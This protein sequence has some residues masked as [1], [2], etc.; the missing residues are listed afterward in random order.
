MSYEKQ[1]WTTGEVI[2]AEKLNHMEDGIGSC[3]MVATATEDGE[4]I[5]LDKTYN[6]INNHL[7]SGGMVF[8]HQQQGDDSYSTVFVSGVS[9]CYHRIPG[10]LYGVV[11]KG[12]RDELEFQ[13]DSPDGV[14]RIEPAQ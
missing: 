8:V 13:S 7:A 14:L 10:N 4:F 12:I 1:T 6:E 9:V 5:V 2:T 3:V 11:A